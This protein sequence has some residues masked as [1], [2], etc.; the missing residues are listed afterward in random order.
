M[1]LQIEGLSFAWPDASPLFEDFFLECAEGSVT[2]LLGP[3][4][5]GKS[6]L[7]RLIAGTLARN[8]GN[9]SRSATRHGRA[10]VGFVFQDPRLLPWKNVWDNA[11]LALTAAGVPPAE[12]PER[13]RPLLDAVGLDGKSP[14]RSLSGGMAQR[15]ALVR[16]LALRPELLLLDEP[17]TAVDPLLREGLYA[18]AQPLWSGT[19]TV[20]VTHDLGEAARLADRVVVL[21]AE[22][23]GVVRVRQ[24]VEVRAPHPRDVSFRRSEAY[25]RTVQELEALVF[26]VAPGERAW[27]ASRA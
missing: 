20:L 17:F 25:T 18:V 24:T 14:A 9:I 3:S 12:H 16:A 8:A 1:S 27:H 6:T 2:A 15:A 26:D 23:S 11:A 13:L 22:R 5:V 19:T 21:G 10:P 7:L 4:G